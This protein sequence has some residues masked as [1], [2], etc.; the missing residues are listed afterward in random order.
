MKKIFVFLFF[1]ILIFNG[2]GAN[3]YE[4]NKKFSVVFTNEVRR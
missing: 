4:K 2:F 1:S 3:L